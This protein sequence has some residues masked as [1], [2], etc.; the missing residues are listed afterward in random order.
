[1]KA[2]CGI[3]PGDRW[4]YRD[5]WE[6]CYWDKFRTVARITYIL[7]DIIEQGETEN[8]DV[9]MATANQGYK[10]CHKFAQDGGSWKTAWE[11]TLLADPFPSSEFAGTEKE[12]A[13]IGGKLEA[14]DMLAAR[15]GNKANASATVPTAKGEED[16]DAAPAAASRRRRG[17][18]T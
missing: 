15:I 12:L 11:M 1:M 10:A 6:E 8:D 17:K 18:K 16:A 9:A 3:R 7:Q 2:K 13:I 5:Y 14:E 4:K